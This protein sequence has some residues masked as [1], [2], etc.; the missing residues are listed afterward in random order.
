MSVALQM[1]PFRQGSVQVTESKLDV[2][3]DE[4]MRMR[5]SINRNNYT[6]SIIVS[7]SPED[8]HATPKYEMLDPVVHEQ[9]CTPLAFAT[10]VP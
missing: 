2:T 8:A 6:I 10:H 3:N 1:P 7:R 4:R 5:E 9:D